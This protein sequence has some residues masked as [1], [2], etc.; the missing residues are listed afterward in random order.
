PN[1]AG[2]F[3]VVVTNGCGSITSQVATL[4]V[5]TP[6]TISTQPQNQ[7]NWG[8]SNVTFTL[9]AAGSL[10]LYYQW[11]F[12]DRDLFAATN[13]SYTVTSAQLS[14][15]GP[16]RVVITNACGMVTSQVA[17][18][19]VLAPPTLSQQPLDQTVDV[20]AAAVFSVMAS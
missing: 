7:T 4:T 8:Q 6:P 17:T 2:P 19:T 13:S 3:R 15:A 12:N 9:V 18:L 1:M 20:G 5:L 14:N 16:Y 10:P 11:R